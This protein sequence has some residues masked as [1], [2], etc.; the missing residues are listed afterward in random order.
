MDAAGRDVE[1]F[2][3]AYRESMAGLEHSP[4]HDKV[5]GAE[6]R[7]REPTAI[8]DLAEKIAQEVT[9]KHLTPAMTV[10]EIIGALGYRY[11]GAGRNPATVNVLGWVD[12]MAQTHGGTVW[13]QDGK[14]LDW[15][16]A[17][18]R[19]CYGPEWNEKVSE[20]ETIADAKGVPED[21]PPTWDD[22]QRALRW[23]EGEWPEWVDIERIGVAPQ[24]PV[25]EEVAG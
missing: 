16:Q 20:A 11:N 5:A 8:D 7:P 24:E 25:M 14:Q 17:L 2:E 3:D 23:A 15:G 12:Y 22:W 9:A 4:D 18:M 13:Q 21:G 19:E 1:A 10:L 6:E